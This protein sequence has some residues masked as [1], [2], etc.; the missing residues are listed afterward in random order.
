MTADDAAKTTAVTVSNKEAEFYI[1]HIKYKHVCPNAY[2][3]IIGTPGMPLY[4][5]SSGPGLV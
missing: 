1:S 2:T 3:V 5:Y 4:H